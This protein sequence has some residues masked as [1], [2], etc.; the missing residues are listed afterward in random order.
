MNWWYREPTLTELLSDWRTRNDAAPRRGEPA[1]G[2]TDPGFLRPSPVS[3][4]V[5]ESRLL[6]PNP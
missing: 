1:E 2:A 5:R 4:R 3:R 6:V